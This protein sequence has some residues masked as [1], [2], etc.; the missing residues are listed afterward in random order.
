MQSCFFYVID[1]NAS[2]YGRGIH[3]L[4]YPL[5]YDIELLDINGTYLIYSE[6]RLGYIMPN[7]EFRLATNEAFFV[8][9]II[10]YVVDEN[11]LII[12]FRDSSNFIYY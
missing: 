10:G 9:N 8:K 11:E 2:K 3:Y 1:Y 6:D 4:T 5:L 12:G 7:H